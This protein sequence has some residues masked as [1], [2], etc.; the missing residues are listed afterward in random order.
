MAAPVPEAKAAA[1][2]PPSSMLTP[3]S[4]VLRFGLSFREVH[5]PARVRALDVALERG[6]QINWGGHGSGCRIHLVPCVNGYSFDFHLRTLAR[7]TRSCRC[8]A[9]VSAVWG[10]RLAV[11]SAVLSGVAVVCAVPSAGALRIRRMSWDTARYAQSLPAREA[12]R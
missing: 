12:A 11:A 5:E 6:G 1:A 3:C 7:F 8:C 9:V 2:L 4:S 10:N